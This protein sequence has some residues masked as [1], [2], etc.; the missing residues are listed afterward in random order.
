MGRGGPVCGTAYL[1]AVLVGVRPKK[2]KKSVCLGFAAA[3]K[4]ARAAGRMGRGGAVC[5]TAYLLAVLVGVRP[6]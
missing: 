6:K 2:L 1:L 5:G 4:S 3:C